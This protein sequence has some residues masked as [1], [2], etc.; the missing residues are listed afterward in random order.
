MFVFCFW[1]GLIRYLD[2]LFILRFWI[3]CGILK[4][5]MCYFLFCLFCIL[6]FGVFIFL[7]ELF[8]KRGLCYRVVYSVGYFFEILNIS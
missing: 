1:C 5:S 2:C 3:R 8:I 4:G 7:G 6:V